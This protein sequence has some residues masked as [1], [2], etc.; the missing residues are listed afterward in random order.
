M[1]E[2]RPSPFNRSGALAGAPGEV[3]RNKRCATPIGS[4]RSR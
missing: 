3:V 1:N 4:W 2:Y